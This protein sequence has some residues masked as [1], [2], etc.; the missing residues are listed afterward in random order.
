M[1]TAAVILCAVVV[2]VAARA[3]A[4]QP[5]PSP[6]RFSVSGTVASP[7]ITGPEE[8]TSRLI[9]APQPDSPIEFLEADF[10]GTE[11]QVSGGNYSVRD[12]WSVTT[13]NRSDLP[14]A[15]FSVWVHVSGGAVI[16]DGNWRNWGGTGSGADWKGVLMPDETAVL[17]AR[18][19]P[20]HGT[21]ANATGVRVLLWVDR[22]DL[23]DCVCAPSLAKLNWIK[24]PQ[25]WPSNLD[26]VRWGL[27][28]CAAAAG[29]DSKRQRARCGG[30]PTSP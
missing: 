11:L 4:Q 28:P 16:D 10:T 13:R 25:G 23:K 14:I 20:G 15:A 21:S 9:V 12:T 27:R 5:L 8:V 3:A 30:E 2:L 24:P 7:K 19:G 29:T 26:P 22:V 17:Q 6:C 1:R 18:S